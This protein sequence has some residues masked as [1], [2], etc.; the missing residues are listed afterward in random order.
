MVADGI[1]ATSFQVEC[2]DKEFQ[3]LVSDGVTFTE[4]LTDAGDMKVAI[5]DHTCGN[6]IQLIEFG[7]T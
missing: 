7:G 6:L 4:P 3:R 2:L 5:L 1:P